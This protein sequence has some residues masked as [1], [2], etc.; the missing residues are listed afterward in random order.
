MFSW[1]RINALGLYSVQFNCSVVSVCLRPHGLQHARF[2]YHQLL[3][4][5]Q[6][7][8]HSV[9]DAIQ[10]SHPLSSPFCLQSFPASGS[11]LISQLFASS[12]QSIGASASSLVLSMN[13][14]GCF[15]LGLTSLI[16]L[17]FKGLSRVFFNTTVQK[18]QFGAQLSLVQLSHPSM[19]TGKAIALTRWTFV[20]KIIFLLFKCSGFLIG[21]LPKSKSLLIS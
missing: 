12:A 16:S 3:E 19:T 10:Q 2:L 7:H 17:L 6:T 14:Q 15:P 18:H 1:T 5:A 20:T 8:V 21:F 13:I 4:V 9:R 11:F